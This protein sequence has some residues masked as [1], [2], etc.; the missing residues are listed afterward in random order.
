MPLTTFP[1]RMKEQR[2]KDPSLN[3]GT[4]SVETGSPLS[5]SSRT[6]AFHGQKL[7]LFDP[8]RP[9]SNFPGIPARL[10]HAREGRRRKGKGV[11]E[12]IPSFARHGEKGQCTAP[13]YEIKRRP[14]L[15]SPSEGSS[16]GWREISP[17]QMGKLRFEEIL[18]YSQRFETVHPCFT[19]VRESSRRGRNSFRLQFDQLEVWNGRSGTRY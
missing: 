2:L 17:G 11:L 4:T 1:V 18:N 14:S 15:E 9:L 8:L 16:L 19:I 13:R 3:L 6:T 5:N 7:S 12:E 10:L